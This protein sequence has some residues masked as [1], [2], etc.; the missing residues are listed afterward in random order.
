MTIK[1]QTEV[2]ELKQRVDEL[3]RH[4]SEIGALIDS[5][6]SQINTVAQA[7]VGAKGT[8]QKIVGA[9]G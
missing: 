5:L 4:L 1:M 7:V 6:Q 2:T 9:R 8:N 3:Q